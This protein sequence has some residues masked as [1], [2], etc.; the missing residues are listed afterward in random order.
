MLRFARPALAVL[1]VLPAHAGI[2]VSIG[3]PTFD[4]EAG[5]TLQLLAHV[6]G[7]ADPRVTWRV[8]DREARLSAE[9]RFGAPPQV[10]GV[11]RFVIR[12]TSVADPRA[13][14]EVTVRVHPAGTLP[15]AVSR[16][17]RKRK[18][19]EP[20]A[21]SPSRRLS[22]GEAAD[23]EARIQAAGIGDWETVLAL[24]KAV[25]LL[26][27]TWELKGRPFLDQE[28]G[29]PYRDAPVVTLRE[30]EAPEILVG[31]GVPVHPDLPLDALTATGVLVTL[32]EGDAWT[33][34]DA[35][36]WDPAASLGS[37]SA[38]GAHAFTAAEGEAW[39]EVLKG[40]A[41]EGWSRVVQHQRLRVR[42]LLPWL[43]SDDEAGSVDG[44]GALARFQ[45]PAGMVA[46]HQEG[47]RIVL[48]ADAAAHVIRRVDA[49]GAVTTLLGAPGEPGRV[50]GQGGTARLN[51]PTFLVHRPA[52]WAAAE[53]TRLGRPGILVADT[54]NHALRLVDAEGRMATLAGGDRGFADG[55]L[56]EAR[57][58]TPRGLVALPDGTVFVAD[59]GNHRIRRIDP[60]GRVSTLAGTGVRGHQDG[61]AAE[62]T[63]TDLK[64][65]AAWG[66]RLIVADGSTLRLVEPSG[67]VRTV[68]GQPGDATHW[69]DQ[70]TEAR[71]A[72]PWAVVPVP[73][74]LLVTDPVNRVVY[75]VDIEVPVVPFLNLGA[76][77]EVHPIFTLMVACGDPEW[78]RTRPGLPFPV[79][80][81]PDLTFAAVAEPRALCSLGDG[82]HLVATG[83]AIARLQALEGG[84]VIRP[85]APLDP[86]AAGVLAGGVRPGL[87]IDLWVTSDR[88]PGDPDAE[89]PCLIRFEVLDL[90][91]DLGAPPAASGLGRLEAPGA[92]R[93]RVP[94][95][96]PGAYALRFRT[97]SRAGWVNVADFALN[98]QPAEGPDPARP[99]EPAGPA[100][101]ED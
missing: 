85:W 93:L 21:P 96:A 74:G 46:F 1:T 2:T 48:V 80:G 47:Q 33:R 28:T 5:A 50:D 27:D 9:G 59:A 23:L 25:G 78:T 40:D 84:L 82:D 3:A 43:G 83:P 64:G 88:R 77:V 56:A 12:A 72:D 71:L 37:P 19:E 44:Q 45:Q 42:G 69:C 18:A 81:F 35:G 52:S 66:D 14:A 97:V 11:E 100:I 36:D 75:R 79:G 4:V 49:A 16:P 87:P 91:G 76:P 51:A 90:A 13:Q 7:S 29:R 62:A 15:L 61:A 34:Q 86:E 30:D 39:V 98:V 99:D 68:L 55:E 20:L 60:A 32:R 101:V 6:A 54:G 89:D 57:F 95:L 38:L 63:F 22:P 94:A 53:D 26:G 70:G 67:Q 8:V 92:V 31:Y 65:L 41:R 10:T 24:T 73:G 58:D 17:S